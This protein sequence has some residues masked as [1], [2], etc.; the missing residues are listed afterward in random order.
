M[1]RLLLV[2]A[3]ALLPIYSFASGGVQ[4][5][6]VVLALL[7]FVQLIRTKWNLVAH[8][9]ALV[10]LLAYVLLREGY[11]ILIDGKPIASL[12]DA[13]YL[14]FAIA[15][16]FAFSRLPLWRPG[17]LKALVV[18]VSLSVAVGLSGIF[19]YGATLT[20]DEGSISRAVGTFNNPNQLAYFAV[21][22]FSIAGLL[23][24]RRQIGTR[25]Y[26][27]LLGAAIL[28]AMYAISKAGLLAIGSA[29]LIAIG[30]VLNNRRI[31]GKLIVICALVTL[32][33]VQAYSSG[34]LDDFNFTHRLEGIG[35]DKDDNLTERGYVL[36]H[37]FETAKLLFGI[38]QSEVTVMVGHEVH[39]TF[40]SF[41]LK[42]GFFGFALFLLFW[43]QWTKRIWTELGL[44]G[45][46]LVVWPASLYGI[47][48]N[49][50][51]F[52]I[53]WILVG[54]SFNIGK[55]IAPA[56]PRYPMG[57]PMPLGPIQALGPAAQW[58]R[59]E[60]G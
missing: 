45:V 41:L 28:L 17:Y 33:S 20:L 23:Y 25:F 4:P 40:W 12:L 29:S 56:R 22:I 49:G 30:A 26:I 46:L 37:G 15:M 57:P 2:L 6:H 7:A 27:P 31:S 43:Y 21:C 19:H 35:A 55:A 52:A 38:G 10:T 59:E 58:R 24:L 53:F 54:L 32:A 3:M 50:S 1:E 51:R 39:S 8:D 44:L 42:Y 16:V 34:A 13:V 18:G 9:A 14:T 11:A 60:L 36:P 48:H 47:T 5:A